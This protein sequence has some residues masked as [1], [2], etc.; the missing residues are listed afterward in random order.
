MEGLG[1]NNDNEIARNRDY[2]IDLYEEC[3]LTTCK[4]SSIDYVK[5]SGVRKTQ[6]QL[7]IIE[8][9]IYSVIARNKP[10]KHKQK[11]NPDVLINNRCFN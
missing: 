9:A 11:N 6:E 2:I 4:V 10:S 1:R 7:C 3:A 5:K 8:D